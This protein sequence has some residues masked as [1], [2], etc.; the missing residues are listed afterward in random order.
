MT[1]PDGQPAR[2][3]VADIASAPIEAA[4]AEPSQ[5]SQDPLTGRPDAKLDQHLGRVGKF[6]GGGPEKAG[7]IAYVVIVASIFLIIVASLAAA[8]TSQE[9]ATAAPGL[10]PLFDKIVAA[11]VSLITGALGYIF[12]AAKDSK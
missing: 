7:N 4:P 5:P 10:I 1:V 3:T 6:V 12:G 9:V 2:P 8:F 11:S